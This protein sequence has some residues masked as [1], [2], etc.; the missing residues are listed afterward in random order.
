[1]TTHELER[2]KHYLTLHEY[3]DEISRLVDMIDDYID[4]INEMR[5]PISMANGLHIS[6]TELEDDRTNNR[7]MNQ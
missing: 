7:G 4:A 6:I 3:N 2:I 1:M 5:K